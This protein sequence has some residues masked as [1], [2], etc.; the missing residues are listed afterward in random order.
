MTRKWSAPPEDTA[1]RQA[2]SEE[3]L[4]F[5]DADTWKCESC[6]HEDGFAGVQAEIQSFRAQFTSA[7]A[8]LRQSRDLQS[9][10]TAFTAVLQKMEKRLMKPTHFILPQIYSALGGLHLQRAMQLRSSDGAASASHLSLAYSFASSAYHGSLRTLPP[11]SILLIPL[12][13]TQAACAEP[14]SGVRLELVKEASKVHEMNY[15][16]GLELFQKRFQSDLERMQVTRDALAHV[17]TT[18]LSDDTDAD[19]SNIP[20]YRQ[21]IH[22]WRDAGADAWFKKSDSFDESIR[23]RF[24][25]AVDQAANGEFDREW[26]KHAEGCLA[27]ILLLDQFPRNLFRSSAKA[28]ATDEHARRIATHALERKFHQQIQP[29]I[30][31]QFF[32]LPFEHSESME[33]QD[34]AVAFTAAHELEFPSADSSDYAKFARMH[35]EVIARF[36]RF[37]HRNAVMGRKSTVEEEQFLIAEEGFKG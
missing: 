30:M 9:G 5:E 11:S 29:T 19:S 18:R 17:I 28:F 25:R 7:D 27:L 32:Y 36:G 6:G 22:F 13:L 16:G 26:T 1:E 8:A 33:D 12:L 15:A 14:H 21:I 37:P 23:Q 3:Y 10:I 4:P 2:Q 35:R 31:R 34:R 24:S 20:L